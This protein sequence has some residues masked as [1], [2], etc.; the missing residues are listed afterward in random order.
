MSIT[1][2]IG[3]MFSGKTTEL[4]RLIERERILDRKCLIIKF[5]N[6]NRYSLTKIV[7]HN[8]YSYDKCDI[9]NIDSLDQLNIDDIIKNYKVIGVEEGQFFNNI[10]LFSNKLA[11]HDINVYISAL[12]GTFK[13]DL[14]GDIGLI[15]PLAETII[16]L[17]A[18]CM[19]CKN[20]DASFTIRTIKSD[21]LIVIGGAESYVAVCRKC[22]N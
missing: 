5:K 21:D 6:D 19:K 18:I 3:P 2:I 8:S 1:L 22:L 15:F 20:S 10:H 17:K 13:Q 4:I 12:D 7:T 11:N 16:K 9:L 14:F